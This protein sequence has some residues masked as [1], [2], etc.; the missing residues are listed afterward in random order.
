[1]QERSDR[2][3]NISPELFARLGEDEQAQI[4]QAV[5]Q[6][7]TQRYAEH[8]YR[9]LSAYTRAKPPFPKQWARV[10]VI[11]IGCFSFSASSGMAARQTL[12]GV[13]VIPASII[14]GLIGG[15][16][17]HEMATLV[18]SGLLLKNST[19]QARRSLSKASTRAKG[20]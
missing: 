8:R 15:V 13:L 3:R 4:I 17:G 20:S 18:F 14:G 19:D 16:M 12:G 10:I 9:E 7:A 5:Q 6:S 2:W 1:M 11:T